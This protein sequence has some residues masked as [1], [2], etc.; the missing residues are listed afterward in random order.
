VPRDRAV[1]WMAP[2]D[3]DERLVMGIG[4]GSKLDHAGGMNAAFADGSVRSLRARV[5]AA[6]RRAMISIAGRDDEAARD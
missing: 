5:P 2:S 6:Q 3:A 4:P 1:H